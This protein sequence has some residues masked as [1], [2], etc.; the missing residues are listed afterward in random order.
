MKRVA[1]AGLRGWYAVR[2]TEFVLD[3]MHAEHAA[4]EESR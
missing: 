1:A 4:Q 3:R 2:M